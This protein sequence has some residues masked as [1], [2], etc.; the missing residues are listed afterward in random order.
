MSPLRV[1]LDK[2][3]SAGLS[4]TL[5]DSGGLFTITEPAD[6]D[7]VIFGSDDFA[8]V[9]GNRLFRAYRSKAICV[10]ES[11][12]PTFRLPGLYA[13]NAHS[14]V[15]GSR[16]R[17][18]NY[19]ISDRERGN[20]EVKRL[21]G[22]DIEKRYLYSFMGGSNSWARKRLFRAVVSLADTLI[23][24]TDSYNHWIDDPANG[25]LRAKQMR[26]YAQVMAASKF[27]LCPRG[28]G[29]SSYRLFESMSL[30]VAPVI[31][32]DKWRPIEVI[33]W[34]F[35][36]FIRESQI[37]QLDQIVRSHESEWK[38]RGQAG[39]VEFRRALA[40]DR[41]AGM[42]HDGIVEILDGWDP[43]REAVTLPITQVRAKIRFAYWAVYKQFKYLV[44]RGFQLTG[45]NVPIQLNHPIE[46][47][48]RRKNS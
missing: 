9:A 27:T 22:A 39:Q 6:A 34:N 2:S 23:E 38:E 1:H 10:T 26:R 36:L 35:A 18:I 7:V 8:Y 28:C 15:T 48:L 32:S 45:R 47:Q 4:A 19:F 33:D 3:C 44:L 11:D 40:P 5:S 41:V 30:G 16:T 14:L 29:L 37:P 42:L 31:I 20:S 21:I 24:P 17:T 25:E 46:V 13:A 12:I 43:V